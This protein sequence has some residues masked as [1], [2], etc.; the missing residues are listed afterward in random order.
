MAIGGKGYVMLTGDVASVQTAVETGAAAIKAKGLL[1]QKVVIP[2]P[3][4][5]ILTNWI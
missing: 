4:K 5:E 2:S 3:R 1:V